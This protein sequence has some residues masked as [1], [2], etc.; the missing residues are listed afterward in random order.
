MFLLG[1]ADFRPLIKLIH[2][3]LAQDPTKNP[4]AAQLSALER[5]HLAQL[6]ELDSRLRSLQDPRLSRAHNDIQ[7]LL[8]F[9]DFAMGNLASEVLDKHPYPGVVER[10][11]HL[12]N[13]YRENNYE[14]IIIPPSGG[15]IEPATG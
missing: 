15:I 6:I 2:Y 3:V 14:P 12:I 11:K 8:Q 1:H 4:T 7:L 5:E 9:A 13:F 10:V